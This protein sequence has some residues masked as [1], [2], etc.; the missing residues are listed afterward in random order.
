MITVGGEP[1]LFNCEF[2]NNSSGLYSGGMHSYEA[3]PTLINCLFSGNGADAYDGGAFY[4]GTIFA[5]GPTLTNCTFNRNSAGREGGGLYV[6]GTFPGVPPP[7]ITNC[8]FRA[9]TDEGGLDESGQIHASAA[10][11]NY[12]C[13]QGWTGGWGGMGNHGDD[14]VFVPGPEGCYYLSQKA[15]GDE[16][17]SPCVDAGTGSAADLELD[18]MTTRSDEVGDTGIVDM[19]YHYPIT[20]R[21]LV[22]GDFDRDQ[23]VNLRDFAR[24]QECLTAS[25]QG[26]PVFVS[27]CC[28]IFDFEPDADVDLSDHSGFVPAMTGP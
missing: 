22:M 13:I 10:V 28:R 17:N 25:P 23:R 26:N 21:A 11:I 14:P 3:S 24:V 6:G 9:N 18:T 15:A 20:G 8:I 1:T 16:L 4:A 5:R 2:I 19:G 7:L 27:P 12:S